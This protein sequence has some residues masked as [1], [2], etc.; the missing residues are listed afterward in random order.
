[1]RTAFTLMIAGAAMASALTGCAALRPTL[2]DAK[3]D[4]L[5]YG[6]TVTM[7]VQVFAVANSDCAAR[8]FKRARMVHD[9]VSMRLDRDRL[10]TFRCV[11]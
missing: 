5:T 4:R 11:N 3:G 9:E 6:Y 10:A 2:I 1:M 8:G 7:G